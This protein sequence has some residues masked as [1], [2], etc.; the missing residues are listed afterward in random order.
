MVMSDISKGKC[1]TY[2]SK[3]PADVASFSE[4]QEE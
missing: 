4:I 3:R 1:G 2:Y